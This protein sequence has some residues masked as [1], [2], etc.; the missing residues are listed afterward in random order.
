L[1]KVKNDPV[2][3]AKAKEF[4]AMMSEEAMRNVLGTAKQPTPLEMAGERV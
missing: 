3:Q 1:L 2:G 4:F